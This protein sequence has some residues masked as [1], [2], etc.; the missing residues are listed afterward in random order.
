MILCLQIH[1]TACKI[2]YNLT[3][4]KTQLRERIFELR[5]E[6]LDLHSYDLLMKQS[7]CRKMERQQVCSACAYC[8]YPVPFVLAVTYSKTYTN[9][10]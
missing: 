2:Q 8:L 1:Y 6:I 7:W 5:I 9:R 3:L 4:G 10:L